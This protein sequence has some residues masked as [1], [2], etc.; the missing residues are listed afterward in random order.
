MPQFLQPKEYQRKMSTLWGKMMEKMK[1]VTKGPGAFCIAC[2]DCT[3]WN[4]SEGLE[5][6]RWKS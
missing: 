3:E 5:M 4:N 2:K 1:K 6:I